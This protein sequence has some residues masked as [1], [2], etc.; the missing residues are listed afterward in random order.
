MNRYQ[1]IIKMH[2]DRQ[3][4]RLDA[5]AND[6]RKL[7][8]EEGVTIRFY[9]SYARRKVHRNSDLDVLILDKLD[10]ERSHEIM[11]GIERLASAHE[12]GVDIVEA[13]LG[14]GQH[15]MKIESEL[16]IF[17]RMNDRLSRIERDLAKALECRDHYDSCSDIWVKNSLEDSIGRSLHNIYCGIEGILHDFALELDGALPNSPKFHS[18]L[19]DQMTKSSNIRPAVMRHSSELHHLLRFRHAFRNVYD[20]E[21]D[22]DRL[23]AI[24]VG[25][26]KRVIPDLMEGLQGMKKYLEDDS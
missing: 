3:L 11:L 21:L 12:L 4:E 25:V 2:N 23:R 1:A 6:V 18:D 19:L 20:D 5:L 26:E 13:A 7:A 16:K 17:E 8:R 14:Q 10:L 15:I 9:G 22:F 24:L